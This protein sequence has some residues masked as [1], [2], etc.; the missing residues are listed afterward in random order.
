MLRYYI[1]Y[2]LDTEQIEL[3]ME[4]GFLKYQQTS[5]DKTYLQA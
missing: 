5:F 4:D 1:E 3:I 2:L